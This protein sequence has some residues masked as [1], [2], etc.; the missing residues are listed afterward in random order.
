MEAEG[1]S[2]VIS[3][4]LQEAYDRQ[5]EGN[6]GEWRDLCG[7]HKANNV[8]TVT[9]GM[10]FKSVMECGA[11]DGSVLRHLD[12]S[13]AFQE[14]TALEISDSAIE[15]IEKCG[16]K[17][18]KSVTKYDGL[19]I[20]YPDQHFDMAY[21]THVLEHVEHPRFVIREIA[22]VSK[23]QVFEVPLDYSPCIDEK[24]DHYLSYGHISVFTPSVFKFMLRS[25]GFEVVSEL[26]THIPTDVRRYIDYQIARRKKTLTHE[27]R[28]AATPFLRRVKR[29][30]MG[31]KRFEEF[32]YSAFTCLT[33]RTGSLRILGD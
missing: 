30:V 32:A 18:L 28:I 17:S 27:A 20:P 21:C 3:Q 8:L 23:Y 26:R 1:T 6:T 13:G 31:R 14:L 25:E 5:Y 11:G 4:S 16:A 12:A 24:I 33:R 10:R 7:K 2:Q 15:Q 19:T 9:S 22:R 29:T